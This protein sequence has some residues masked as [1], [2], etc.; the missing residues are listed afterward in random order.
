[1]PLRRRRQTQIE[2]GI[3]HQ[4]KRIRSF[5]DQQTAHLPEHAAKEADARQDFR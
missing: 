5:L 2:A 3:I 4:Q 1:M